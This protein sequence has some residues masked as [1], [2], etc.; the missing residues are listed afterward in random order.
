MSYQRF[1]AHGKLMLTGEY[2]VLDGAKALAFPTCFGQSLEVQNL[3]NAP[4]QL[5]WQSFDYQE[6]MW[7]NAHLP[8]NDYSLPE[9]LRLQE[10]L[11]AVEDL[12]PEV[13]YG[14]NLAFTTKLEFPREWGLGSSSTLISLLAQWANIDAYKLLENTFGGS[15]YDIACATSEGPIV[16]QNLEKEKVIEPVEL[17]PSWTRGAYFVFLNEKKNSRD[18]IKHYRSLSDTQSIVTEVNNLTDALVNAT[19]MGAAI[20]IVRAHEK[21]MSRTLQLQ[22]IQ[23]ERFSDFE[24]ACKSLGAWGGD[25][26]LA[27]TDEGEAY[28]RN[29]FE[30]KGFNTI[31]TFDK[32]LWK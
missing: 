21:L 24:G 28:V 8:S 1:Y 29:Y 26:M 30:S 17:A 9:Y 6:N 23:E 3:E 19:S 20:E 15:A 5:S 4:F 18:A 27:L 2:A 22:A 14:Q 32:L 13:F 10:I 11:R 25:F 16:Y 31:F 12:N 7:L